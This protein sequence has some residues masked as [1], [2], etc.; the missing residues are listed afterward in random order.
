MLV[1]WFWEVF[2]DYFCCCENVKICF[3]WSGIGQQG[4]MCQHSIWHRANIPDPLKRSNGNCYFLLNSLK[5]MCS[6]QNRK[7]ELSDQE[8][9]RKPLFFKVERG[10]KPTHF[11]PL[12]TVN[13]PFKLKH[14]SSRIEVTWMNEF[15]TNSLLIQSISAQRTT[16]GWTWTAR[17]L[18]TGQSPT[19]QSAK[20]SLHKNPPKYCLF[21]KKKQQKL[22]RI[23][24]LTLQSAKGSLHKNPPKCIC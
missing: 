5:C 16:S 21:T 14:I 4:E 2:I 13:Y 12:N 7:T 24:S 6:S 18:S 20:G 9:R 1:V 22:P 23:L 10:K 8:N 15:I 11:F 3:V 19:L 17:T